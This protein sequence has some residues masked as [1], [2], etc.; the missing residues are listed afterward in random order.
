M[1]ANQ[2]DA[3]AAGPEQADVIAFL[4]RPATHGVARV[5]I[6]LDLP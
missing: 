6:R 3:A 4:A 1:R 5:E 2:L